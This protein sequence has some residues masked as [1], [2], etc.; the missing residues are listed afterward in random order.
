M[1]ERRTPYAAALAAVLAAGAACAGLPEAD[2]AVADAAIDALA[3]D[4]RIPRERIEVV[5]IR[6]VDWPNS[7]LGC[8]KPGV[9]YLDVITAGH[10][11]TLRADGEVYT[12]NEGASRTAICRGSLSL[13]G[14]M[15]APRTLYRRQMAEAQE[16]LAGRLKVPAADITPVSG[17]MR[18]WQDAALGCPEPGMNYAQAEVSGW[19]LTLRHGTRDYTYHTDLERTIPCP[20]IGAP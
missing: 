11:V 18:T 6:A 19:V 2:R 1:R 9:A 8:A 3:A 20:A 13:A 4:L 7:A 15:Q 16:D 17:E 10:Q 12:V 5:S 14:P